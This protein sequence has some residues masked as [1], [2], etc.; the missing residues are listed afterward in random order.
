MLRPTFFV[1]IVAQLL[2][3]LA[4]TGLLICVHD[5][6][7]VLLESTLDSCCAEVAVVSSCAADGA[8]REPRSGAAHPCRD[9]AFGSGCVLSR[10]DEEADAEAP[11]RA[12]APDSTEQ[13]A[14]P[15]T[16]AEPRI[17]APRARAPAPPAALAHIACVVLRC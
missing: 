12:A 10:Q 5:D 16:F 1:L 14:P 3:V 9:Y 2:G 8:G 7:R 17:P 4:R 11:S 15:R 13:P 6:G